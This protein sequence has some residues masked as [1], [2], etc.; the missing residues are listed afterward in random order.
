MTGDACQYSM[1][2][3]RVAGHRG[4]VGRLASGAQF[5]PYVPRGRSAIRYLRH[6]CALEVLSIGIP[7]ESSSQRSFEAQ[8]LSLL[9]LLRVQ[10]WLRVRA[11]ERHRAHEAG[12]MPRQVVVQKLS[13]IIKLLIAF[14]GW[15]HAV[16]CI[17]ARAS[18][19][20]LPS[21]ET[22]LC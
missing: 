18:G 1:R 4:Y 21:I 8:L 12:R 13:N 5:C 9:K 10:R 2:S 15:A 11:R 22:T 7:F 20:R 16:G 19:H 14:L 3:N 6:S 17:C